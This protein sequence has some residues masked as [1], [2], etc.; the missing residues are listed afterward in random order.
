M[1]F[2]KSKFIKSSVKRHNYTS[3]ETAKIS[4]LD[5]KTTD[6]WYSASSMILRV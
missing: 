1:F 6:Y 4:R 3:A 2:F 5:I